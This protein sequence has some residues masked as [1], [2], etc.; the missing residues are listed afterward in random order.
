[1]NSDIRIVFKSYFSG[2]YDAKLTSK[3][4]AFCIVCTKYQSII[5]IIF[6]GPEGEER[7]QGNVVK[8]V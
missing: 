6:V 4:Q 2:N 8:A 5:F 1:M 3:A 7:C